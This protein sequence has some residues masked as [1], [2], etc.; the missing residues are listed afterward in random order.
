MQPAG[1]QTRLTCAEPR[2]ALPQPHSQ[3]VV[4]L[5]DVFRFRAPLATRCRPLHLQISEKARGD[6]WAA[7][8]VAA[9]LLPQVFACCTAALKHMDAG[10]SWCWPSTDTADN[11]MPLPAP[12]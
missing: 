12:Q 7:P 9:S 10:K 4:R 6:V 11:N 8:V 1:L 2:V 5:P 3:R